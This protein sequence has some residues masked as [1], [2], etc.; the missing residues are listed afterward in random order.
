MGR[1]LQGTKA[2]GGEP[3]GEAFFASSSSLRPVLEPGC[4]ICR[5]PLC[6]A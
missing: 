2:S 4:V 6:R 5:L 3:P 1:L